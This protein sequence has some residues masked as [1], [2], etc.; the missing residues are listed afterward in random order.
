M[1]DYG[2]DQFHANRGIYQSTCAAN[3][4][5]LTRTVYMY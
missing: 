3:W 4:E 2:L 5:K 1:R